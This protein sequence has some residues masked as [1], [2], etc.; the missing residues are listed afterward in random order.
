MVKKH[1][2]SK[3]WVKTKQKEDNKEIKQKYCILLYSVTTL[4]KPR[5]PHYRM[6]P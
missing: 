5:V 6:E 4:H 2:N 3:K 1:C